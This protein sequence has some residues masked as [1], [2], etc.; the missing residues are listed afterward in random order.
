MPNF[1]RKRA[2]GRQ[3]S[4]R[5]LFIATPTCSLTISDIRHYQYPATEFVHR[6]I[7]INLGRNFGI[8]N[9]K[10]EVGAWDLGSMDR[11]EQHTIVGIAYKWPECSVL[12]FVEPQTIT[13]HSGR[14]TPF[15]FPCI[16]KISNSK[17]ESTLQDLGS[18]RVNFN[19]KGTS[20]GL[21]WFVRLYGSFSY[22]SL[23]DAFRK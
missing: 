4:C 18:H 1:I 8:Q 17:L 9:S 15:K 3:P 21:F 6:L 22:T 2:F 7:C 12:K 23:F 10:L 19:K 14:R 16:S 5:P 11:S 20:S 13:W